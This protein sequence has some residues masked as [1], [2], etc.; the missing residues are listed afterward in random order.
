[1]TGKAPSGSYKL[2]ETILTI[3]L[4]IY[5]YFLFQLFIDYLQV[6][7][8]LERLLDDD[9]DMAD[10][11]LSRKMATESPCLVDSAISDLAP[12]SPVL[13]SK[14]SRVSRTSVATLHGNEDT[15]EEL[16]MLL[17]VIIKVLSHLFLY[18][19]LKNQASPLTQI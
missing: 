1:M 14:T 11:Y 12:N 2:H 9:N 4:L 6:R 3:Y 7:D 8:E 18:A 13:V 17:E 15:V 19:F 10:L 16:E 5:Y